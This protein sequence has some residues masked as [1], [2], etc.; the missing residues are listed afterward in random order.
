V[1]VDGAAIVVVAVAGGGRVLVGNGVGATVASETTDPV[2][3]AGAAIPPLL[4]GLSPGEPHEASVQSKAKSGSR[5]S[6]RGTANS[7]HGV[8]TV[9]R[10]IYAAARREV[11]APTAARTAA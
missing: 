2:A 1:S 4:A 7:F 5:C 11:P 8:S 10:L 3:T 6:L 9:A